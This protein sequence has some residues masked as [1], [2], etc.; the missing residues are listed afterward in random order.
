MN[1]HRP[2]RRCRPS[3]YQLKLAFRAADREKTGRL[4]SVEVLS[5]VNNL[6]IDIGMEEILDKVHTLNG[7]GGIK[8]SQFV[9]LVRSPYYTKPNPK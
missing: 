1:N 5:A 4:D 8:Y 3:D 9:K 7:G 6:G 2:T